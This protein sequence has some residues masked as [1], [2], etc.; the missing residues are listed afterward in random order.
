MRIGI[1]IDDT[2]SESWKY[3]KSYFKKEF[4]ISGRILREEHLIY[5]FKNI[6]TF[7]KEKYLH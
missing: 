3:L 2:I 7:V 1:D 6:V 4:Q 5:Q